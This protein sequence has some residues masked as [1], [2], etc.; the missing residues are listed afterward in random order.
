MA[1]SGHERAD[2]DRLGRV[3][4]L[5]ATDVV[6]ETDLGCH[7]AGADRDAHVDGRARDHVV[8]R[9]CGHAELAA[10]GASVR[11]VQVA[12]VVDDRVPAVVGPVAAGVLPVVRGVDR[13]D[14]LCP[15]G[16]VGLVLQ[17]DVRVAP[18]GVAAV[19]VHVGLADELVAG[20]LGLVH[21]LR[22]RRSRC[23][24]GSS[25]DEEAQGCRTSGNG[26]EQ[27]FH[28]SFSN[29]NSDV[30][31]HGGALSVYLVLLHFVNLFKSFLIFP[32]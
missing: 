13:G 10:A 18:E 15:V 8:V 19:R 27:P 32:T 17:L 31:H 12:G 4:G 7:G 14:G 26:C 21:A 16:E 22:V 30:S 28:R 24:S 3:P 2:A 29:P 6:A 23:R 1:E 20:H 11:V 5:E 9:Q 25:C